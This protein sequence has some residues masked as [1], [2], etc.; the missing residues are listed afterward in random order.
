MLLLAPG[1]K[2]KMSLGDRTFAVAVPRI[3]NGQLLEV[4]DK[5]NFNQFKQLLKTYY[6]LCFVI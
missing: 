1:G 4:K 2:T 3:W 5:T 6:K